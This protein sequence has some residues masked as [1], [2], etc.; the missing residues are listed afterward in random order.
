MAGRPAPSSNMP[1]TD[2]MRRLALSLSCMYWQST[3]L[4]SQ[5]SSPM[6]STAFSAVHAHESESMTDQAV[7]CQRAGGTL[8]MCNTSHTLVLLVIYLHRPAAL[9]V[10]LAC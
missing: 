5:I 8:M 10:T 9:L 7:S 4:D 3:R 6:L 1:G 2:P